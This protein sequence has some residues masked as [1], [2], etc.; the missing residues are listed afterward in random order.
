MLCAATVTAQAFIGPSTP[1]FKPWILRLSHR[2]HEASNN[3]AGTAPPSSQAIAP[4]KKPS[5]SFIS[6]TIPP[7]AS[8]GDLLE[9]LGDHSTRRRAARRLLRQSEQVPADGLVALLKATCRLGNTNGSQKILAMLRETGTQPDAALYEALLR[10]ANKRYMWDLSLALLCE[11]EQRDALTLT[12]AMLGGTLYTCLQC[13][14]AQEAVKLLKR[15]EQHGATPG[16]NLM[17]L[18]VRLLSDKNMVPALREVRKAIG[19]LSVEGDARLYTELVSAFGRASSYDDVVASARL[20]EGTGVVEKGR[21]YSTAVAS[22][23]KGNLTAP[24]RKLYIQALEDGAVIGGKGFEAL[25]AGA[26]A[27]TDPLEGVF[28]LNEMRKHVASA[29]ASEAEGSMEK[30]LLVPAHVYRR[31][32]GACLR[33]RHLSEA[34]DLVIEYYSQSP[35]AFADAVPFNNLVKAICDAGSAQDR[36]LAVQVFEALSAVQPAGAFVGNSFTSMVLIGAYR[37]VQELDKIVAMHESMRRADVD[38]WLPAAGNIMHAYARQGKV[39]EELDTFQALAASP[40]QVVLGESRKHL[41]AKGKRKK[42]PFAANPSPLLASSTVEAPS[43]SKEEKHLF[44]WSRILSRAM[45][46]SAELGR[47][48]VASLVLALLQK[49]SGLRAA[50]PADYMN[51]IKAFGQAKRPGDA[52]RVLH[53][54]NQGKGDAKPSTLHYNAVLH[55]FSRVERLEEAEAVFQEMRMRQVPMDSTTFN[56]LISGFERARQPDRALALYDEMERRGIPVD[57]YVL[58]SLI[59]VTADL[60]NRTLANGLLTRLRTLAGDPQETWNDVMFGAHMHALVKADVASRREAL[61]LLETFKSG[62]RTPNTIMYNEALHATYRLVR[63]DPEGMAEKALGLYH[64]MLAQGQASAPSPLTYRRLFKC[65]KQA[66]RFQELVDVAA[67]LPREMLV[68]QERLGIPVIVASLRAGQPDRARDLLGDLVLKPNTSYSTYRWATFIY[69]AKLDPPD[70][71][72]AETII[73]LVE[74][75]GWKSDRGFYASLLRGCWLSAPK[76]IEKAFDVYHNM[77]LEY[78]GGDP[79]AVAALCH[80]DRGRLDRVTELLRAMRERN[81]VAAPDLLATLLGNL[82]SCES[83]KNALSVVELMI[84]FDIAL[85]PPQRRKITSLVHA[86]PKGPALEVLEGLGLLRVRNGDHANGGMDADL[87]GREEEGEKE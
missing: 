58:N 44:L 48:D 2:L 27:S 15:F 28:Y 87:A 71:A 74:E 4:S 82:L 55:A 84:D 85:T 54:M 32:I 70:V 75:Q 49:Y 43:S 41:G 68:S 57:K 59:S 51:L 18:M 47:L 35:A 29:P 8:V 5:S 33:S 3:Q 79:A 9:Y 50:S 12:S 81:D 66:C 16:S 20:V 63:E 13:A 60:R 14:R 36:A 26:A 19:A 64:E 69:C 25:V 40:A 62:G 38:V 34:A 80:V 23:L 24:A 67:S 10:I 21:I 52:L 53:V 42:T 56:M 83:W 37:R 1:C 11:A 72:A 30:G 6:R 73:G 77:P 61:A 78:Q 76:Q 46:L 7:S 22:L 86:N 31:L 39:E 65:L 17:V 45:Y